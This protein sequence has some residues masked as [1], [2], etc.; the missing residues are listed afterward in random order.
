MNP[1]DRRPSLAAERLLAQS[2]RV[3]K[4]I[5]ECRGREARLLAKRNGLW[6]KA[7]D[8]PNTAVTQVRIADECGVSVKAVA[9]VRT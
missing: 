2:V 1:D 5:R 8:M 9:K 4:E 7:L 6:N 3:E